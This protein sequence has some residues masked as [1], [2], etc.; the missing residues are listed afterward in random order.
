VHGGVDFAQPLRRPLSRRGAALEIP[1]PGAW[2]EPDDGDEP[3]GAPLVR[4]AIGKL[5]DLVGRNASAS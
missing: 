1:L 3:H 4:T 5:R 2:Q